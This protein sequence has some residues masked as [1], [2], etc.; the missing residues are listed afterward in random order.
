ML[1]HAGVGGGFYYWFMKRQPPP[2][3]ADL[4]LTMSSLV[5]VAPNAGGGY[6]AKRAEVWTMPKKGK[7]APLPSVAPAAVE[8]KEEVMR[9]DAVQACPEPCHEISGSGT[10]WGGGTGE[11]QGQYI[12]VEAASRKPRWIRN[13]ITSS[14]YPLIA[15]RQGKDGLVVL[16]I[17]I[18]AEGRVR[19]AQLQQGGYEA[20]NEVALR[21]VKQAVFT[22]AYDDKNRPVSCKVTLP[23]R[24]ELR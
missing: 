19:D 3:V 2:I 18:D 14:D 22:P 15:R 24:F 23:I 7:K 20:L 9:Q 21:K 1:V 10:G 17:L 8:T 13:F 5:P 12:P 4:D 6:G 16:T 11:G